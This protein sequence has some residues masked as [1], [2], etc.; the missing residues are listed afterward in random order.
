MID[1]Y[2]RLVELPRTVDGVSVPNDDGSFDIYINSKLSPAR[3][4][5]ALQHELMHLRREHFYVDMPIAR[6]E[7]QADGEGLNVVL[8]PPEG[9]LPCFGSEAALCSW[10]E[11][12][13]RQQH[14]RLD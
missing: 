4:E 14:I 7:K 11:T 5:K 2:V 3:R 8:S 13:C 6:I 1:Y 12:V 10:L 9:C